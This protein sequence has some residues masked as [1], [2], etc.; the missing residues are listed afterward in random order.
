MQK[1]AFPM[2]RMVLGMYSTI[3]WR[4]D[5]KKLPGLKEGPLIC[6]SLV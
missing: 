1:I 3:L 6:L 4:G 5:P 2:V